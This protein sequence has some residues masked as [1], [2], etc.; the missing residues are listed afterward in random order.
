MKYPLIALILVSF[1]LMTVPVIA[2]GEGCSSGKAEMKCVSAN[3]I[4]ETIDKTPSIK[5]MQSKPAKGQ[6]YVFDVLGN[7]LPTQTENSG[8][9]LH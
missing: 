7:R 1:A 8:K 6:S 9:G 2:G 4:Q 5:E 3:P